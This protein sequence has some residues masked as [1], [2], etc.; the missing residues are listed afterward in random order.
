MVLNRGGKELDILGKNF[1]DVTSLRINLKLQSVTLS[2]CIARGRGPGNTLH[3]QPAPD[4]SQ[5]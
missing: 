2:K 4:N 3:E 1:R 5:T